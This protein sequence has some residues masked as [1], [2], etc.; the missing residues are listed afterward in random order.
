M[1]LVAFMFVSFPALLLAIATHTI[2][3]FD[4]YDANA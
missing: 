4:F 2:I 3:A 1:Y